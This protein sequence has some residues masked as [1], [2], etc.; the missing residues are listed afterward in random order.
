MSA[1][2]APADALASVLA[3]LYSS[4]L[5]PSHIEIPGV[6]VVDVTRAPPEPDEDEEPAPSL[7]PDQRLRG[8][9]LRHLDKDDAG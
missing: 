2:A 6:L 3:V 4:G 9:G 5:R 8:V 1:R 7:E